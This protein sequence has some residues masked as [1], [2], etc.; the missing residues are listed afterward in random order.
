M[1][2]LSLD[3]KNLTAV[4]PFD[5]GLVEAYRTI[6][7]RRWNP[8]HKRWEFPLG[9]LK[10]LEGVLR[11]R[12]Y[13]WAYEEVLTV[14]LSHQRRLTERQ[15]ATRDLEDAEFETPGMI[16]TL[17]PFQ[18]V[19]AKFV[20]EGKRV[21]LADEMG[22]GKT[23][24]AIAAIMAW[25][26]SSTLV[27]CP[28]SVKVNWEREIHKHTARM[29]CEIITGSKADR[30]ESWAKAEPK[31]KIA[32]Y[33]LLLHDA[34]IMPYK[35]GCI[36]ADEATRVKNYRA[37]TTKRLKRLQCKYAIAMSGQPIENTLEELH[38]IMEFVQPTLLGPGWL[39]VEQHCIKDLWGKTTGYR[40]LE[41]V[42]IK[43]APYFLR[44]LKA[45]VEP[46]LPAKIV[47]D[48]IVELSYRERQEYN[49]AVRDFV[50][51]VHTIDR[52]TMPNILAKLTRLKQLVDYPPLLVDGAGTSKLNELQNILEEIG[53]GHR[54][55]IFTQYAEV[56]R[57][58]QERLDCLIVTGKTKMET[59]S[60][61]LDSFESSPCPYLVMT[62]VGAYGINLT[63]ADYVIHYDYPWNPAKLAQR[64]DRLHR[65]G[66]DKTVNV[67]NLK[68]GDTI[69]EYIWTIL[70]KKLRLASDFLA[71][72]DEVR[73]RKLSIG[74]MI[75][76]ARGYK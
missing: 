65:I 24:Q 69:D 74:D 71:G 22:L 61:I 58:I 35:W 68:G 48:Y 50:S 66:Q 8:R 70:Y 59:R 15:L 31:I 56:A 26:P 39:F 6:P 1:I 38:S 43:V 75:A 76:L 16:S 64:E 73:Q 60:D 67:I 2:V 10:R 44:R 45:D 47:Q 21:L 46:Q 53:R 18:R 11:Q 52:E 14:F 42:Q 5:L 12:G 32:N 9:Q 4:S 40:G 23:I 7:G 36:V 72:V 55:V 37:Q 27:L 30:R 49:R 19:G 17:R 13:T 41:E 54:V 28:A 3:G 62:E 25:E 63:M 33:E 29:G 51:W 34:D 20:T 57:A